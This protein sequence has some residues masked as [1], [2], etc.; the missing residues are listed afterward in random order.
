MILEPQKLLIVARGQN[1]HDYRPTGSAIAPSWAYLS[2]SAMCAICIHV[3][4][5]S[6]RSDPNIGGI[7]ADCTMRRLWSVCLSRGHACRDRQAE[8][9]QDRPSPHVYGPVATVTRCLQKNGTGS[10]I[11]LNRKANK[12][13]YST[14]IQ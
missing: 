8:T 12:A 7:G 2:V 9:S 3:C 5:L 6:Q 13:N 10:S 4:G 11:T 14:K 1:A